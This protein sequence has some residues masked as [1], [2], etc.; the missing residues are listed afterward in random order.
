[1]TIETRKEHYVAE[2]VNNS[3]IE[4]FG[5]CMIAKSIMKQEGIQSN[6]VVIIQSSVCF[7]AFFL[8]LRSVN[9]LLLLGKR[10]LCPIRSFC[11]IP[12]V[13]SQKQNRKSTFQCRYRSYHPVLLFLFV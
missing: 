8:F 6:D 5:K 13:Q 1:M 10:S 9:M 7:S 3:S 4:Y 2:M 12:V 11:S